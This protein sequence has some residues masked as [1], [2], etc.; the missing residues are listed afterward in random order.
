MNKDNFTTLGS[1]QRV[2]LVND[3]LQKEGN[4]L[5]NVAKTLGIKY[6]TYTKLSCKKTITSISNG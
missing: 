6:S 1:K 5:K 3:L 4:D 2:H